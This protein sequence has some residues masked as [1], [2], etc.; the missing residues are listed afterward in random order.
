MNKIEIPEGYTLPAETEDGQTFEELVTFRVEGDS[1]VPTMIA[2][3]EIAAEEA[4]DEDEMEDEAA[5]EMEAGA[6]PMAGM[7]KRIMGMA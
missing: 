3:V 1:L 2:G 5:D 4:E 6:S 7:G